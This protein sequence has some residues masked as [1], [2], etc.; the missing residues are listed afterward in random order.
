MIQWW[1]RMEF[2]DPEFFWLL[3]LLPLIVAY[4]IWQGKKQNAD[5][6]IST[7]KGFEGSDSLLARLRPLLLVLRLLALAFIIVGLARPQST[8]V[9]TKTSTTEGI[10]IVLAVDVS[11]SMLAQDFKPDRLEATKRVA[12]D[13]IE[14]RP[15]DR[16]GV[17]VYAA[18]S[19]TKTPITTD[20]SITLRAV[21]GIEYSS[22]LENGTAIGMGLATS[23]NRLK[24][25]NSESKVIILMTDGVNNAG[26]IDPKIASELAVEFGIKV[27]TIGI[28][29]N[30]NAPSPVAQRGDGSFRFAMAPVEI[31]EALMK[32]IAA[33]T[34]GKYYRATNNSKLKEIY[35]EIDQLETTE[36]EEFK[37]Y[38]VQEGFRVLVLIALG[39]LGLEMLLRYTLF[40][41]AA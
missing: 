30:G 9:N 21:E 41:T 36:I 29:T 34:G 14:G 4:Y 6:C 37:F 22:V 35:E 1:N 11:A 31:D 39:L 2:V 28:G 10:D 25:S 17:V 16:I 26:F 24:E 18:E 12:L 38:N 5:V 7:L 8:D 15:S 23:V 20:Q 33:D 32:Q 3:L 27:Y 13:F 19:Y 40:R